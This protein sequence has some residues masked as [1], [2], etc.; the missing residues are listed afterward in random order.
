MASFKTSMNAVVWS[1]LPALKMETGA[2]LTARV[3]QESLP[4]G[5]FTSVRACNAEEGDA[6]LQDYLRK[7]TE[8]GLSVGKGKEFHAFMGYVPVNQNRRHLVILRR[9]KYSSEM[10]EA[11]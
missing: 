4:L 3:L 10:R 8:C 11:A 2:Y 6:P 7:L 9:R 1:E 5:G